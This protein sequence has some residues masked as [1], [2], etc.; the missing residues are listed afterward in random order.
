MYVG[1]ESQNVIIS[2][3]QLVA[4]RVEHPYQGY[5]ISCFNI[6]QHWV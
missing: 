4:D 2:R 1:T 5:A 6:V 3:Y